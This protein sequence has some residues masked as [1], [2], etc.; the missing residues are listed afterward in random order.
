MG[1]DPRARR[2]AAAERVG[3]AYAVAAYAL[4][5]AFPL[6]FPLLKPAGPVEILAQRI[7][8]SLVAVAVVLA[9]ARNASGLAAVLRD[10]RRM[11]LLTI[12]AALIAINWG[13]FIY[14]V[15]S[16][17][18]IESSLGYFVT[19]LVS[20]AFGVF[21]FREHLRPRQLAALSLGACAVVVL[22]LDYGRPPWIA[23][24][25][26]L[27]FG[28]YGLVKKLAG[29][30][31]AESLAV[32][33]L[34]LLVPA[35]GY[36]VVL[37]ASSGGTFAHHSLGHALLLVASGPVT[38]VPLLFFS[39]AVTRVALTM[40]GMLQ[41]I[42]PVLQFLVGLLLVGEAMPASRWIGF[43]LVWVALAVLS[44]DGMHAVRRSRAAGPPEPALATAP[45]G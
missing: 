21:I 32:E 41:Y 34:V 14:A 13:T 16:D 31:A 9:A 22:T 44:L 35:I 7:V 45:P 18:V 19:P 26:A 20:V 30:G 11:L 39:G 40:I 6:F 25:L 4:W 27:S 3:I 38:A 24:T 29:V 15:N 28:T 8:W 23:L 1:A 5:G 36:L 12:A 43:A 17:H 42:A 10:R 33:T 37:E 2:D